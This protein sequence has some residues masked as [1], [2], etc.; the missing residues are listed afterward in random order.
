M[1]Q[2][3]VFLERVIWSL[4]AVRLVITGFL[5]NGFT[6]FI[7]RD[8]F[9]INRILKKLGPGSL[10]V[11]SIVSHIQSRARNPPNKCMANFT[12]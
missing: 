4:L 7:T 1:H 2:K 3:V 12:P 5:L 6:A 11:S 8:L 9:G 10:A